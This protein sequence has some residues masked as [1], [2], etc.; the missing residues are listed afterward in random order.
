[1]TQAAQLPTVDVQA[2][3]KVHK[4]NVTKAF[5]AIVAEASKTIPTNT[6]RST[7]A[8]RKEAFREAIQGLDVDKLLEMEAQLSEMVNVIT[9]NEL[10]TEAR[11]LTP[12]EAAATMSEIMQIKTGIEFLEARKEWIRE[13][14]FSSI[15]EKLAAQGVEDPEK[16][17]GEIEIPSLGKKFTREGCGPR[18]PVLDER[19]LA[20]LL[21]DDVDTVFDTVEVPAHTKQV[22]SEEKFLVALGQNP[23]LMEI[24]EESLKDGGWKSGS[25]HQRDMK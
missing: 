8:T 16:H 15:N 5:K 19:K 10:P 11:E 24:L 20:E 23:A 1:M 4:G 18:P 13:A 3:V 17:N 9:L 2:L 6:D 14:V 12:L 7:V 22:F 21:G 25:F